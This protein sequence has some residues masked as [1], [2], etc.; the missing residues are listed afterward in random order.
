MNRVIRHFSALVF[1]ALTTGAFAC[2]VQ[3]QVN[4]VHLVRLG[5]PIG[6]GVRGWTTLEDLMRFM[7]VM[8]AIAAA[9]L[10]PSLLVGDVACRLF[11]RALRPIV[12]ALAGVAGL[13]LMFLLM[14]LVTPMPHLVVATAESGG[15][16]AMCLT[17]LPGGLVYAQ[18]TRASDLPPRATA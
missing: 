14:G 6:M 2:V 7:P 10:V 12:L 9:A 17:G 5:A 15:L 16:A 1:A 18:L 4:I 8:V 3:T 11:A 13:W